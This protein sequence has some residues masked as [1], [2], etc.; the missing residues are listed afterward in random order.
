MT[1]PMHHHHHQQPP[2]RNHPAPST[3]ATATQT[4]TSTPVLRLRATG[5]PDSANSRR[6]QWAE[7]VVDN[8]G[9]GR[10]RSKGWYSTL[11]FPKGFFPFSLLSFLFLQLLIYKKDDK[12]KAKDINKKLSLLHL[13]RSP[14]CRGIIFRGILLHLHLLF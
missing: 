14:P 3:T 6:I 1:P 4:Q 12:Q 10:K 7:D 9:L 5:S 2:S 13:P 8:E 11:L